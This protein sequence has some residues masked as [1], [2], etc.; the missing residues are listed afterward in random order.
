MSY[1][2]QSNGECV[3]LQAEWSRSNFLQRAERGASVTETTMAAVWRNKRDDIYLSS[4][5]VLQR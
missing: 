1:Q 2:K 4:R 5:A 3:F